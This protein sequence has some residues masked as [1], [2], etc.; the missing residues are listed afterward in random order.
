LGCKRIDDV[1]RLDEAVNDKEAYA[2]RVETECEAGRAASCTLL[3]IQYAFGTYGRTRDYAI[4]GQVLSKA[5]ASNDPNGCYELGVLHLYGRGSPKDP[6]RAA[7][8]FEQACTQKVNTACH[9]LRDLYQ[10]GAEGLAKDESK[11]SLY[12][13]KAC[14]AGY[15][16]DC[17]AAK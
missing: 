9:A 14:A 16:S 15:K 11:A 5:C 12:A 10:H 13:Q 6:T 2:K 4:A 17:E 1:V 3:G 7:A 8:L